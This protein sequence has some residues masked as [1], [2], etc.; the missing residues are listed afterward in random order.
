MYGR[1]G[2]PENHGWSNVCCTI[3]KCTGAYTAKGL[4][5]WDA[6]HRQHTIFLAKRLKTPFFN[7]FEGPGRGGG[8]GELQRTPHILTLPSLLAAISSIGSYL[9]QAHPQFLLLAP[10]SSPAGNFSI[11]PDI[12]SLLLLNVG[13]AVRPYHH[14]V[15][16]F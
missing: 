15:S 13:P 4:C 2:S 1:V 3:R 11:S 8:R 14:E 9:D 10:K 12:V 7:C 5:S 16:F 6:I